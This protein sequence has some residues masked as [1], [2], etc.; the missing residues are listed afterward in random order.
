MILGS[1][2]AVRIGKRG[3]R[4]RNLGLGRQRPLRLLARGE[5]AHQRDAL[6]V[7]LGAHEIGV[8]RA[9]LVGI[10]AYGL[11]GQIIIA[12]IGAVICI[13]VWQRIR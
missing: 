10:G 7:L 13:W 11:I 5:I 1:F 3:A 8:P 4:L 12:T 9:G 2:A 6:R